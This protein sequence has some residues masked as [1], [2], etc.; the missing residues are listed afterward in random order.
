MLIEAAPAGDS[1]GTSM[2]LVE[3]ARVI[4]I[5]GAAFGGEASRFLRL[6]FSVEE[7]EIRAG[8]ER[9]RGAVNPSQ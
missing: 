8:V 6:S 9:I 7:E 1:L 2:E 4:T 3:Q 5:P